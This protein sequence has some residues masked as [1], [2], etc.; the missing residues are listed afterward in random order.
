MSPTL[1]AQPDA[2]ITAKARTLA[3]QL[4]ALGDET[5]LTLLLLL[6][7]RPRSVRELTDATGLSQTLVSHHLTPLREQGLITATPKGRSNIYSVCCDEIAV[8]VQ[9][10]AGLADT[11]RGCETGCA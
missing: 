9:M 11:A 5:R 10:L 8:P 1:Q 3:P 2:A 4:K 6:A 7:E